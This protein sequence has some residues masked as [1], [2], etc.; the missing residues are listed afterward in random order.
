MRLLKGSA[1]LLPG[2]L[3]R[4]V[5]GGGGGYGAPWEREPERVREDVLDGYVTPQRA[6]L[7]YGVVFDAQLQV[8]PAATRELRAAMRRQATDESKEEFA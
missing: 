5:S 8:V 3:V 1:E 6:A 4:V 2:D 7:D